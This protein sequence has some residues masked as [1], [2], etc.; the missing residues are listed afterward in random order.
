MQKDHLAAAF[1]EFVYELQTSHSSNIEERISEGTL[2]FRKFD[3]AKVEELAVPLLTAAIEAEAP[4]LPYLTAQQR[5]KLA[6][7]FFDSGLMTMENLS[8]ED[9]QEMDVEHN[10]YKLWQRIQKLLQQ[11][12][13]GYFFFRQA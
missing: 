7:M 6:E 8:A 12:D 5:R 10:A 4:L 1:E 13:S 11:V 9:F 2:F 3:K